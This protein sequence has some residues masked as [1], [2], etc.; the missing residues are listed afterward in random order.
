MLET[1]AFVGVFAFFV[2]ASYSMALNQDK[3]KKQ[4][5][6]EFKKAKDV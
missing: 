2:Y 6:F 3:S 4:D 1:A 5:N